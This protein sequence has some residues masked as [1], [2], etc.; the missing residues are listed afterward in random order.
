M[1]CWN[2]SVRI[3]PLSQSSSIKRCPSSKH[4][5]IFCMINCFLDIKDVNYKA[6]VV[7]E[8]ISIYVNFIPPSILYIIVYIVKYSVLNQM[9]FHTIRTEACKIIETKLEAT[10]TQNTSTENITIFFPS[11]PFPNCYYRLQ[12]CHVKDDVKT[13]Q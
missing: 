4:I 12:I 11:P 1:S 2:I 13:N 9:I 8:M 10:T 5:R 6:C 3:F 7:Q